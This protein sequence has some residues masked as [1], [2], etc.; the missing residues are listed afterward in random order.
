MSHILITGKKSKLGIAFQKYMDYNYPNQDYELEFMSVR[1]DDWQKVDFSQYDVVLHCAGV[2]H[3]PAQEYSFYKEINVELTEKI[4]TK[5]LA[6]GVKQFVYFSTMDI[7]SAGVITEKT[8]PHPTSLY[9]K[10]KL[11]AEKRLI[12]VLDHSSTKLA[13]IRCCPVIGKSAESNLEGYMKAF[14]LPVFPLMFMED[15][16][17]IL[18][19]D[20]LCELIKLI[21]DERANGVFYP[22]NL[23]PLSVA[24]I[25]SII[26][27]KT[28]KKTILLKIPKIFWIRSNKIRR[29]YESSYY[30]PELS[31]HFDYQYIKMD[32]KQAIE[33]IL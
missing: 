4:A 2:Y 22:Q 28:Q 30:S 1:E 6:S 32:S 14:K 23:S 19:V 9:G 8:V 18:H 33:S 24:E 31:N 20:T 11:E 13:V 10:S 12:Q 15:K 26:K 16:R 27:N 3:A 25:L 5:A 7:Y 21:I 29:I 17:S